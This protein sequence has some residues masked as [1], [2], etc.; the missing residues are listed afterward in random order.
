[1]KGKR[2]TAVRRK[3]A[4]NICNKIFYVQRFIQE[5]G[6]SEDSR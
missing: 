3:K 1:M 5:K 2:Y 4:L 6:K